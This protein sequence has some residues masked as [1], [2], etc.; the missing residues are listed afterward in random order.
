MIEA[1]KE[2]IVTIRKANKPINNIRPVHMGPRSDGP[3]LKHCTF[4]W[5]VAD[6]YQELCNFEIE[7]RIF[8]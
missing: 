5:K 8:S 2:A 1:T 4:D 7:V 3:V 6:K